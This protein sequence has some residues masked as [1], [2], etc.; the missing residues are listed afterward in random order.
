LVRLP[1]VRKSARCGGDIP[2]SITDGL[3]CVSGADV[4]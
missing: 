1:L 4:C 2:G 3:G